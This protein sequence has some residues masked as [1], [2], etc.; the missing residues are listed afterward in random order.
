M[1]VDVFLLN[2]FH[3]LVIN[4]S[5]DRRIVYVFIL[6]FFFFFTMALD[7]LSNGVKIGN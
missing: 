3:S 2:P 4:L 1:K 7:L 6:G 5:L